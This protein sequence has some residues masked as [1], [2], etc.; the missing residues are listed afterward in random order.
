MKRYIKSSIEF[1]QIEEELNN[2]INDFL[3]IDCNIPDYEAELMFSVVVDD[4][5]VD[6]TV[7]KIAIEGLH[8]SKETKLIRKLDRVVKK[9]DPEAYFAYKHIDIYE[10]IVY[11]KQAQIERKE[12]R[13]IPKNV[14]DEQYK[15]LMSIQKYLN[16]HFKLG[17][18][19]LIINLTGGS[20][21]M[22]KVRK[23]QIFIQWSN[24]QYVKDLAEFAVYYDHQLIGEF[25]SAEEVIDSISK[26]V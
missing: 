24:P 18:D 8:P 12:S 5:Y 11:N 15:A 7:Y 17:V 26:Y 14:S 16:K 25:D 19:Y 22:F 21:C 9:Y 2:T 20:S 6:R 4:G 10:A 23:P 13:E 3:V 1:P